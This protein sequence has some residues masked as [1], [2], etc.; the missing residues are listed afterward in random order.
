MLRRIV[1]KVHRVLR[2][3]PPPPTGVRL[4]DLGGVKVVLD[5]SNPNHQGMH[6]NNG[7]EPEL[8]AALHS[9]LRPGEVFVDIGANVGWH[10]LSL[11]V[12]RPDV[13]MAYAFEPSARTFEMLREGVEAN[14]CAD[15]CEVRRLALSDREGS[16]KFKTF[17][18]MGSLHSSLY[19]LGDLAFVEEEVPLDTLDA[20]ARTFVAPPAVIKCDVEGAE[21]DV[22]RGAQEV[23][24]GKGGDPPV[25]FM[26]ANYETSGMAGFFPWEMIEYARSFAPYEGYLIRGG[27]I[28][29]LPGRTALR[30]GDTLILAVPAL[31]GGRFDD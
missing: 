4:C 11:L 19:P 29:P 5:F 2:P 31:H 21:M 16:A 24:G 20:Q 22:L 12:A 26:E 10:T 1:N 7:F 9:V 25:W 28:V 27:R 15:R 8:T 17:P 3:P 14:G 30:H 23:L 13:R 18:E 6:Y